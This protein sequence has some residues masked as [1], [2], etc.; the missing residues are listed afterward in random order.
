MRWRPCSAAAR[1]WRASAAPAATS[2][3][4][5]RPPRQ[6]N[7]LARLALDVFVRAIRHYLGAFMLELGGIDVI[8]F[9]G[10][11]GENS[12]EIRSAVCRNLSAFGVE[13]DE[14]KNRTAKGEGAISTQGSAVKVLIVPANEE[15]I[16]ARETAEVVEPGRAGNAK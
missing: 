4:W 1:G 14:D 12:A 11:I 3:T 15:A 7:R 10:G 9:S 13:L 16:V 2:A 5:I 6:G 8:T